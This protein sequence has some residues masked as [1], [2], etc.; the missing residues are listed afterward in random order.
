ML[1]LAKTILHHAYDGWTS[2]K[3]R[4]GTWRVNIADKLIEEVVRQTPG[5]LVTRMKNDEASYKNIRMCLD[6]M[7][8]KM[9]PS[10]YLWFQYNGHGTNFAQHTPIDL[11]SN[12]NEKGEFPFV[13]ENALMSSSEFLERISKIKGLKFILMDSCCSDID[14]I[15][16]K[17]TVYI[18]ASAQDTKSHGDL[19]TGVVHPTLS[20]YSVPDVVTNGAYEIWDGLEFEFGS[21]SIVRANITTPHFKVTKENELP[22]CTTAQEFYERMTGEKGKIMERF[23]PRTAVDPK[24][25]KLF[26]QSLRP[27]T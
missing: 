22:R 12:W 4:R 23:L 11:V 2:D 5:T 17:D 6:D 1:A 26:E 24:M 13:G 10:D 19:S 27:L 21:R 16:P 7:A 18:A 9:T 15:P 25:Y 20:R 3:S 14:G 8:A